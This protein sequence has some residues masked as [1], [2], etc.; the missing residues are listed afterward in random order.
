VLR[1]RDAYPVYTLDYARR[2]DT[3]KSHLSQHSERISIVGRGGTF[4]YNNADHSIEMGLLTARNLLGEVHD[5]DSVNT[6]PDYHEEGV[7]G[8]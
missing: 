2:V 4:R 5:V 1:A 3:L 6:D 7:V 8:G